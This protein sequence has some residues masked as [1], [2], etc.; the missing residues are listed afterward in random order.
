[1]SGDNQA[2]NFVYLLGCLALVGSAVAVRRIPLKTSVKMA[3]GWVLIFVAAFAAFTLKDDFL[4]LGRRVFAEGRG[5]PV[6]VEK[7]G[8]MRI[9]P[10]SDGHF[11]VDA[12]VN[13]ETV[14][15][16]VDSGATVTSISSATAQR[17]HVQ[18]S[19]AMPER[20]ETG[21]GTIVVRPARIA[22]LTLGPITRHDFRVQIHDSGGDR[23]NVLGMNFL[24][25]LSAWGV[26][27]RSLVLKP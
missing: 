8:T 3:L 12:T 5:A 24:S 23:L 18:P 17:A 1:M 4:D 22:E 2:L 7:G 14:R 26:D 13:G 19:D 9:R 21:N 15:F 25:S 11:W 27:Q 10:A 20:V 16:L 6:M